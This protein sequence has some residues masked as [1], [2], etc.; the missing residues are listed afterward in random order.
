M[1]KRFIWLLLFS[2]IMLSGC[3]GTGFEKKTTLVP[4]SMDI[5][6]SQ[7]K[8]KGDTNAWNGVGISFTWTFK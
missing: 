3:E 8:Y 2:I 4:D 7:E 1:I 6:Y 5:G